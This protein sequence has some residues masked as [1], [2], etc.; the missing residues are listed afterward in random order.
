MADC[1]YSWAST[2]SYQDTCMHNDDK[3]R[4]PHVYATGIWTNMGN[5]TYGYYDLRQ[6]FAISVG[7]SSG[8]YIPLEIYNGVKVR[9]QSAKVLIDTIITTG[10]D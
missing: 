10:T 7:W 2:V 5:G 6:D 9:L 8:G 1:T 3:F 4:V